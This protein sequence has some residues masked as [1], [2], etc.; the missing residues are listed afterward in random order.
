LRAFLIVALSLGLGGCLIVPEVP[1]YRDQFPSRENMDRPLEEKF[2]P[3]GT[4]REM[5]LSRLGA[6]DEAWGHTRL[7]YQWRKVVAEVSTLGGRSTPLTNS[8]VLEIEFDEWGAVSACRQ[9]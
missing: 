4:T 9:K 1:H 8:Y 3:I 2:P 5:V 6:P 7:V